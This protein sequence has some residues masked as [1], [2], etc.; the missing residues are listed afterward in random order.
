MHL[1]L[2]PL[3]QPFE[4]LGGH[5]GMRDLPAAL[6]LRRGGGLILT[7]QR[8]EDIRHLLADRLG[9]DPVL[10]V[11]RELD[12]TAA[13][14]LADGRL[15]GVGHAVGVHQDG[16]VH[17]AG[18]PSDRLDQRGPGAEEPLLVGVEDRDQRHLG[19]I[20]S[21]PEQVDPDQDVELA[22]PKITDDL[23]P[24]QRVDL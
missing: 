4:L 3:D 23:D 5:L 12:L 8:Q 6:A 1:L 24:L 18:S 14:G 20:E 19:E 21:L 13:L 2:E 22:E 17:V 9:V 15:H 11:V 16:P 7:A 10:G